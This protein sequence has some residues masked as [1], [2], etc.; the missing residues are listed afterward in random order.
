MVE[1]HE[2]WESTELRDTGFNEMSTE[3][4]VLRD[5]RYCLHKHY[6]RLRNDQSLV[7]D[8]I[9]PTIEYENI[10]E[11]IGRSIDLAIMAP[12]ITGT[13]DLGPRTIPSAHSNHVRYDTPHGLQSLDHQ[14]Y[15]Q[16]RDKSIT[17]T[18]RGYV[19]FA[20]LFMVPGGL[21]VIFDG[22][23]TPFI[24]FKEM[25]EHNE[26]TERYTLISDCYLHGWIY[27]DYFGQTVL[28]ECEDTSVG[29]GTHPTGITS[30]TR[31]EGLKTCGM[32]TSSQ[33]ARSKNSEPTSR[34][35]S[36]LTLKKQV[37]VIC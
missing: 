2:S 12:Q 3:S 10:F 36:K 1:N 4:R 14:H 13:T 16:I 5:V 17:K 30:D 22:A 19:G 11:V 34:D 15:S 9:G 6:E 31:I 33:A 25:N 8:E 37:F 20:S 32:D 7:L 26:H 27:G 23:K 24:L 18:V 35:T 28:D 21:V 29:L